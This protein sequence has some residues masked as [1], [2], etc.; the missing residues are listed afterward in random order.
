MQDSTLLVL[1]GGCC[2]VLLVGV[3]LY[4][5]Q[6]QEARRLYETSAPE[7]TTGGGLGPL[8]IDGGT[9]GGGSGDGGDTGGGIEGATNDGEYVTVTAPSGSTYKYRNPRVGAMLDS[10]GFNI[11]T[12]LKKA[13]AEEGWQPDTING[14][15]VGGGGQRGS[16]MKKKTSFMQKKKS[17]KTSRFEPYRLAHRSLPAYV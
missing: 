3:A 11:I 10:A 5:W 17:K 6:N 4:L 15:P 9:G 13:A 16:P 1:G 14:Q 2:C 12:E 7:D 8:P